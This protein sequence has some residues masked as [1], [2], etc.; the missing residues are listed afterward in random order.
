MTTPLSAWRPRA[1]SS[2]YFWSCSQRAA[3]ERGVAEGSLDASVREDNGAK[4]NAALGTLIHF[5]LQDGMRAKFPGPA[6][7]FAPTEEERA[8]A[9]TLFGSEAD[10][11]KAVD[12][13]ARAALALVPKLPEG[14]HWLAEPTVDGGEFCPPGHIDLL[15]SDNSI[16][17]DL[18]T[19]RIKPTRIKRGAVIQLG[20]YC[21]ATGA[22]KALAIYVDSL[23]ASWAV[24]IEVDFNEGQDAALV[25]EM[26]PK[27]VAY[28]RGPTLN[29]TAYPQLLDSTC[30]DDFC[31]Y[32]RVC[33]DSIVPKAEAQY[34]RRVA[35]PSGLVVGG[36]TL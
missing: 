29:D 16:V 32:T 26:L 22:R 1:S 10:L 23:K 3:F 36:L 17:V 12:A 25:L 34:N 8:A 21:L 30:S 6:K 33:R 31:P 24:P 4:P 5:R 13:A 18:K 15:A 14:V 9:L 19:T 11:D 7:D 20:A 28:W 2:G 35:L 27:L